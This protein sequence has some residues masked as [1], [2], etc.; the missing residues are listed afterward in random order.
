MCG[1]QTQENKTKKTYN[2]IRWKQKQWNAQNLSF[3]VTYI[4]FYNGDYLILF[5]I[6][7]IM[8]FLLMVLRLFEPICTSGRNAV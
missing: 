8:L 3:V 4:I 1:P 2:E 5:L 6:I 7:I